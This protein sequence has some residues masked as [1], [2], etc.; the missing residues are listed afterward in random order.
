[1]TTM[2]TLEDR[3]I[4]IFLG[5]INGIEVKII[6]FYEQDCDCAT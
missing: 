2:L 5:R 6:S 1:M 4:Y 3:L